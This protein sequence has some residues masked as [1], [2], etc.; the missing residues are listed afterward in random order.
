[1][2]YVSYYMLDYEV[3][4]FIVLCMSEDELYTYDE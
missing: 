2:N 1:M 3:A 4:N